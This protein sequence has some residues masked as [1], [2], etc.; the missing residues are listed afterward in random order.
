M[1]ECARLRLALYNIGRAYLYSLLQLLKVLGLIQ[2]V[3]GGN[4]LDCVVVIS[5]LGLIYISMSHNIILLDDNSRVCHAKNTSSVRI[6]KT[7][8]YQLIYFLIV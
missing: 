8:V 5:I 2:I 4:R 6:V 3:S 7:K 1:P